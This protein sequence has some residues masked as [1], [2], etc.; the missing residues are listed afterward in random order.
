MENN[1]WRLSYTKL[2]TDLNDEIGEGLVIR[3]LSIDYIYILIKAK[4]RYCNL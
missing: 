3:E 1:S 4:R 2:R